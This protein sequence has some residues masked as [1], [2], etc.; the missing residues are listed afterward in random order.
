VRAAFF[1]PVR[2]TVGL[3]SGASITELSRE[4]HLARYGWNVDVPFIG[5]SG[6]LTIRDVDADEVELEAVSG[7]MRG[8]RMVL[9]TSSADGPNTFAM[10]AAR[11]DPSDGVPIVAAI[12]STDP[13]FRP[14]LVASGMLMAFRGLR[15]G[16]NEGH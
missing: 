11:I 9:T 5:S 14:G 3:L 15:R 4:Q 2:F 13:A 8:G 12:E 10:L 16:L 1:D 7:A 6:E